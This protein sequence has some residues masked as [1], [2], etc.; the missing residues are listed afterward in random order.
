MFQSQMNYRSLAFHISEYIYEVSILSIFINALHIFILTRK[1]MR[2]SSINILMAAV[3]LFDILSSL[4]HIEIFFE[5]HSN[6]IFT[7]FPTDAYGLVLAKALLIVIN[8]YSRRCSTW[9]IVF[10]ALIR[11]LIIRNPFSPKHVLLKKPRSSFM[12]IA[13]ISAA[14]LPISIFKFLE[15]EFIEKMSKR[16]CAPKGS[17]YFIALSELFSRNDGCLAKHFNL[18]NSFVSDV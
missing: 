3:A 1:P 18:F 8:D 11:T 10:I 5:R 15:F 14:S 6:L 17:Y 13:G 7:C 12:V 4:V 2:T 16:S 9:L